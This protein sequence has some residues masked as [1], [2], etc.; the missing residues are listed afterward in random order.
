MRKSFFIVSIALAAVVT[1]SSAAS[2]KA[3]DKIYYSNN[4]LEKKLADLCLNNNPTLNNMSDFSFEGH[5][6]AGCT[7]VLLH[8]TLD[9]D[10]NRWCLQMQNHVLIN[11]EWQC[12]NGG[13]TNS[14]I[15]FPNI[16][17]PENCFPAETESTT[18]AVPEITTE[19]ETETEPY[20]TS[21]VEQETTTKNV[22]EP[23]TTKEYTTEPETTKRPAVETTTVSNDNISQ[24]RTYAEQVVDLVNKERAK[25]GLNKLTL[26]KKLESAALTRAYE[27][28]K[29]FSHT[30]PNGSSFST[31]LREYN[32]N[33]RGSGENIAWGQ[34]SPEAVMNAWM[35]SSGHRANILNPNFK[36]IGVGYYKNSAGR[37]HWTQLFIY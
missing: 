27:I 21:V 24:G 36:E 26:N 13:I 14:E 12:N 29:S 35:N 15:K 6:F 25:A 3:V 22:F 32:I 8:H 4:L 31:V 7:S 19:N 17:L 23:E 34:T 20:T 16:T 33:Y 10:I 30:R 28:E 5:N 11:G 9:A 18:E 1:V 37:K 2:V